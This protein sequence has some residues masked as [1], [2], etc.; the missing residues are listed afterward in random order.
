MNNKTANT[1]GGFGSFG[2][3]SAFGATPSS[4]FGSSGNSFGIQTTSSLQPS[5]FNFGS[6]AQQP[7]TNNPTG[8]GSTDIG[9]H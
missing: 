1:G 5:G 6:I 2:S 9:I 4:A 7:P 8:S 3:T